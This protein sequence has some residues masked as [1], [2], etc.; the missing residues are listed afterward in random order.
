MVSIKN[1]GRNVAIVFL[2]LKKL[3]SSPFEAGE[4]YNKSLTFNTL[5]N[6]G[7][8][9]ALVVIA[10]SAISYWH[11]MS[12]L[13][14]DTRAN[15]L[16]YITERAQREETIFVLAE[17]N[18]ILLHDDFLEEFT[19]DSP[20]DWQQRFDRHFFPWT[21]GTIRNLPEDIELQDFDPNHH[22]TSF[23]Q[24]GVTLTPDFQ[25]RMTLSYDLVERYGIGWRDRFFS[26]YIALPEGGTTTFYPKAPWG[27]TA[28]SDLDMTALESVYLGD[29]QH[30][31]ERKTLWTGVYT[32]PVTHDSMV[33]AVTPIDDS[34]G[35]HLGS[36]EHDIVLN[37]LLHRVIEDH[38][39]GT[40]NLL[41]R[42]DGQLIAEPNL[43]AQIQTE[44]GNL[45]VQTAGDAHLLRLFA[46]AGQT[47]RA[48]SVVYNRRDREYLAIARLHGP[49]WYLIT[50]Y[51]ESLLRE[52]AFRATWFLLF[53]SLTS[54][55]LEV[56]LLLLV[57]RQRVAT[58]LRELLGATQQV[59]AGQFNVALDT[60]RED[61]LGQLAAAFTQMT[62]QLQDAFI[63]LESKVAE[64][65]QQLQTAKLAADRANQAKS[66]FLASMSHELRTPLN[67]ILGYTQV[68][69]RSLS[70]GDRE[71]QGVSIIHQCG[72]HL[73]NL[74]NDI[75]DLAKIEARKLELNP[76]ASYLPAF[77][78]GVVEICRIRADRKGLEFIYHPPE[79][80]PEAVV[81]DEKRLQQVLINLLGNAIKFTDRGS[82]NLTVEVLES[83]S[84]E[85]H[86][87]RFSVIDTGA[88]MKP[89][90]L[91]TIF[92]PFEQVGDRQKQTEGTGLGLS[93][94]QQIVEL[95][96]SRL[97]VK[98]ELGR[99]STF[100]FEM[101][102]PES[103]EWVAIAKTVEQGAI[104]SYQ[105]EKRHIL[106]V[107][108][109][110]ENRSVVVSLLEPIGFE[111]TEAEN[112]REAWEN[113]QK[114]PPDA[115]ITDLMMPEM[116]G[117]EL[118]SAIRTS[119]TFENIVTIA[120]S[121]SIF[122][123]NQQEAIDAGANVFLPKPVQADQLLKAL[124]EFLKLE[125][126]YQERDP[127]SQGDLEAIVPP[128]QEI[129]E[130]LLELVQDGDIQEIK[131]NEW[132]VTALETTIPF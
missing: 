18:H 29:W 49:N 109:R 37:D 73:L 16:S 1:K 13:A 52:Q 50:V 101:E 42:P 36:I 88:G 12:Q 78:Q 82:V 116:N 62:R 96:G 34:D 3:F 115:V 10:I 31:P 68:L 7:L 126:I 58:P 53:I 46:L 107:D 47:S 84:A 39:E 89:E 122:E 120:S 17:D 118:L 106:V 65:T 95:M 70:L 97:Q 67:G 60:Q 44:A 110:W 26:T 9:L 59:A 64:R 51:P 112:G 19:A 86:H 2:F 21:D 87:L 20:I 76:N 113:M 105:G 131:E 40:Y 132:R 30:N 69:N 57:L 23:I 33:S 71:K 80:L 56:L 24:R 102:I 27:L 119:E 6:M 79:N 28:E 129:L 108:D 103:R 130:Q 32:D 98:S 61:E 127:E 4:Q 14:E 8:R 125:W 63:T 104:A 35:R 22:A 66:D 43:M 81:I 45:S 55:V 38:L 15:L 90:Q 114:S 91:E 121:A 100:W 123:S 93:I 111:V 124:Q 94:S 85:R 25:K 117:Y 41:V 83:P 92:Q 128:S 74:I 77:L 5:V 48:N 72:S 99:G 11:L 54:L 75:L